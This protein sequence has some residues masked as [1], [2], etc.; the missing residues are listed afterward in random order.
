[1]FLEIDLSI[2]VLTHRYKE[3]HYMHK[4]TPFCRYYTHKI[5][6]F[7]GIFVSFE[8]WEQRTVITEKNL[9]FQVQKSLRISISQSKNAKE[10]KMNFSNYNTST[11]KPDPINYAD[12]KFPY[13]LSESNLVCCIVPLHFNLYK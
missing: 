7:S 3:Q 11:S 2:I 6:Y 5:V 12:K 1:M 9:N 8:S 4:T 10:N 13:H